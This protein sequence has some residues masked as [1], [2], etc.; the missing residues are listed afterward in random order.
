MTTEGSKGMGSDAAGKLIAQMYEDL[1]NESDSERFLDRLVELRE[2]K[3]DIGLAVRDGERLAAEMLEGIKDADIGKHHV[4]VRWAKQR[5]WTDNDG[6]RTRIGIVARFDRETGEERGATDA[7]EIF[8]KAYRCSGGEVRTTWLK[9]HDIDPDE[10][11]EG[12]WRAS[13]SITGKTIT[14]E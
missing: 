9:E 4:E 5:K 6:L 10:Y 1:V 3:R 13:V 14:D 11:S 7:I 2:L 12:D 8:T